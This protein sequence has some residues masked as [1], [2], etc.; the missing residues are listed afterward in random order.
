MPSSTNVR[1]AG[2]AQSRGARQSLS[3]PNRVR[4]KGRICYYGGLY[5]DGD[6]LRCHGGSSQQTVEYTNVKRN[7]VT[8]G[9]GTALTNGTEKGKVEA[10]PNETWERM[11]KRKRETMEREVRILEDV[12]RNLRQRLVYLN[13]S[14]QYVARHRRSAAMKCAEIERGVLPWCV[15]GTRAEPFPPPPPTEAEATVMLAVKEAA[16]SCGGDLVSSSEDGWMT[17][18][19]AM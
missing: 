9:K 18:V 8:N 10:H 4:G 12:L 14:Q 1:H 6:E 5:S 15:T 7:N 2:N 19:E 3:P 13:N 16:A 11:R 17:E